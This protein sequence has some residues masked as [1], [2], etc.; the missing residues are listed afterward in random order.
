M[1]TM[2]STIATACHENLEGAFWYLGGSG[3]R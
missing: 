3:A 1:S 2:K